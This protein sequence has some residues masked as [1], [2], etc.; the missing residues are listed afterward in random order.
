MTSMCYFACRL[1]LLSCFA[2]TA[3]QANDAEPLSFHCGKI[4]ITFNRSHIFDGTTT[5]EANSFLTI[6]KANVDYVNLWLAASTTHLHIGVK[7]QESQVAFVPKSFHRAIVE[8][9]D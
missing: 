1:A 2:A 7:G 3:T 8:C 6:R 4:F 5:Q 9:L